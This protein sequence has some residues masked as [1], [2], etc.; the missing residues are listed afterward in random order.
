MT[1]ASKA[2]TVAVMTEARMIAMEQ[3]GH[4]SHRTVLKEAVVGWKADVV[5][6]EVV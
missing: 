6:V 5:A 4:I 2:A 1:A 3:E